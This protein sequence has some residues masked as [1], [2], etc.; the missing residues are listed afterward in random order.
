MVGAWWPDGYP[1]HV[2]ES[3]TLFC[4]CTPAALSS[5]EKKEWNG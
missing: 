5:A 4:T 2:Q 3:L 1:D